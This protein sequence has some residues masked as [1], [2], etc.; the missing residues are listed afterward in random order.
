MIDLNTYKLFHLIGLMLLFFSFGGILTTTYAGVE[1]PKKA[2]T[3]AMATHGL[4][5]LL[6]I[7]AG[8]GMLARLGLAKDIPNWVYSKILLWLILGGAIAL[9]KRKA[10]LAWTMLISLIILG[11]TAAFIGLNHSTF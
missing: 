7:L 9:L 10:D 4:G 3:L 2:K 11:G 8:F 1:L 6:L 5:L